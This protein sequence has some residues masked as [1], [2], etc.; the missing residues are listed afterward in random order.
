VRA[1]SALLVLAGATACAGS[2]P[3]VPEADLALI[4]VTIVDVEAGWL[5]RDQTVLIEGNRIV[6]VASSREVQVPAGATAVPAPGK[7]VIPGLWDMHVHLFNQIR[8][9]PPNR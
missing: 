8:R 3:T 9:R 7:Y 6:H 1:I 4:D 2:C 5:V